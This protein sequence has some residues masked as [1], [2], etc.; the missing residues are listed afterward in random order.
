M[1]VGMPDE[2]AVAKLD[3]LTDQGDQGADHETADAILLDLVS[4]EVRAA[5][6]RA[7]KRVGFWYA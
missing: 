1:R 2:E 5:Y 3:A 7:R 4:P 6:E